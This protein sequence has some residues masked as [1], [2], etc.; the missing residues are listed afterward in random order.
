MTSRILFVLL[1]CLGLAACGSDGPGTGLPSGGGGNDSFVFDFSVRPIPDG[2]GTGPEVEAQGR[3]GEIFVQGSIGTSL[4]CA[5]VEGSAGRDDS[6]IDV[7]VT[8]SPNEGCSTEADT[9]AYD[10]FIRELESGSYRFFLRHV[11]P[12]STDT[13]LDRQLEVE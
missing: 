10:A 12:E 5:Q 11:F 6:R 3:S 2:S 1:V 7:Q 9:F 8:A 4:P 13:V